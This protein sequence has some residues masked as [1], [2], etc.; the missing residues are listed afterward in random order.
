M[1]NEENDGLRKRQREE[2]SHRLPAD[3]EK[4]QMDHNYVRSKDDIGYSEEFDGPSFKGRR[5]VSVS[6]FAEMIWEMSAHKT[7]P[8][9]NFRHTGENRSG[10]ETELLVRC[11]C[12]YI[13]KTKT[14][15]DNECLP[16]NQAFNWGC[17]AA[18]VGY[19]SASSLFTT[20][21]TPVPCAVTFRKEQESTF[22][23]FEKAAKKIYKDAIAEEIRLATLSG[24]F[25]TVEGR[26][27]PNIMVKVDG[28][29]AK[30][31]YG[32]G[33]NS[34]CGIA[35]VIGV[36]TRKV[37][38]KDTRQKTCVVCDKA[39]NTGDEPKDHSCHKNWDGPSTAMESDILAQLF[40][41]SRD[42]GV[43]FGSFVGDGDSNVFKKLLNVYPGIQVRKIGCSNHLSKNLRKNLIKLSE[44][45]A[46]DKKER[47]LHGLAGGFNEI[48]RTINKCIFHYSAKDQ[49]N[50]N[51]WELLRQDILNS[52]R[53]AFGEH[54]N[55]KPHYCDSNL[56]PN[57]KRVPYSVLSKTTL[58][59]MGQKIIL[60]FA[61]N[62]QSLI[63]NMNTNA[64]ECFMAVANKFIEGKRKHFGQRSLYVL[65]TNC[66][67]ISYNTAPYIIP[68]VYSTVIGAPICD[69]WEKKRAEGVSS[70]SQ[71]RKRTKKLLPAFKFLKPR[72]GDRNYGSDPD[73]PDL[74]EDMLKA[75]I[76]TLRQSLM[77][78]KE[79]QEEIERATRDQSKCDLW[80]EERKNRIT[81][82]VCHEVYSIR[83]TTDSSRLLGKQHVPY[84]YNI[85]L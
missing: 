69:M 68:D 4:I 43:V 39:V 38:M 5:L 54:G 23:D 65:R 1:C 55:C 10:L 19:T 48:C 49:F 13:V 81:A 7:C 71:P 6:S 83:D 60:D 56:Q 20:L 21:E 42:E 34:P 79:Q 61:G 16:A 67:A 84:L 3:F 52:P 46:I 15:S 70:R 17:H 50:P 59:N 8:M 24:S 28:G 44:D 85:T 31:S 75:Q 76:A 25:I 32:H 64:A 58:W 11:A 29:W 72:V 33:F 80:F 41:E 62:S 53:H 37:L 30:R 26:T 2:A 12:G 51:D 63:Y 57:T 36:R 18:A 40:R 47:R 22:K 77:V 45:K 66:A 14:N 35:V 73:A 78:S 9:Y 82:S 74:T 27:Y